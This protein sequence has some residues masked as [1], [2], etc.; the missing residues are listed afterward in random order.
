MKQLINIKC[1]QIII[2]QSIYCAKKCYALF[3]MHILGVSYKINSYFGT[4]FRPVHIYYSSCS[5]NSPD[6]LSCYLRWNPSYSPSCNNYQEA[7]VVCSCEYCYGI[8]RVSAYF[9]QLM[10]VMVKSGYMV[11]IHKDVVVYRFAS[12]TLG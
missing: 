12:M 1:L 6:L 3:C 2:I 8:L 7:G 4:G 11:V 9:S 5:R 10:Y